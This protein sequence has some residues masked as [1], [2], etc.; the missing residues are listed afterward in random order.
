MTGQKKRILLIFLFV[1]CIAKVAWC[2]NQFSK[3]PESPFKVSISINEDSSKT[4]IDAKHWIPALQ[5]KKEALDYILDHNMKDVIQ[6]ER[7]YEKLKSFAK[8]NPKKSI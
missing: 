7:N 6:L 8:S 1:F 4:R 3:G 2:D 5:G